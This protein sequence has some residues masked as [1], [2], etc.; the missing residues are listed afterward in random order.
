MNC[1]VWVGQAEGHGQTTIDNEQWI[2]KFP[3]HVDGENAGKMEYEYS[4]CVKQ[5]GITMAETR[6][7]PSENCK[8][9]FGTKR[10]DWIS[11]ET[12][13]KRI[14]MLTVTALLELDYEQPSLDY[15]ELMKLTKILTGDNKKDIENLFC[16]MC[17][18]V[19]AHNRFLYGEG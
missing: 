2:I 5:C 6:L 15:H 12:G 19:F 14:H 1:I 3:S 7:F 18:N 11:D 8:G 16:R 13:E 17:F 9:Y 10:F 4:C